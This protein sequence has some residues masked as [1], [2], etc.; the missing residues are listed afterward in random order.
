MYLHI[1]VIFC[2]VFSLFVLHYPLFVQINSR[3][4]TLPLHQLLISYFPAVA[5]LESFPN[6]AK[7]LGLVLHRVQVKI[8]TVFSLSLSL[9]VYFF[10]KELWLSITIISLEPGYRV[11]D[12]HGNKMKMDFRSPHLIKLPG[13]HLESKVVIL[14]RR[15]IPWG[16]LCC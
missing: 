2:V 13:A 10:L 12:N 3:Q 6:S 11:A 1:I 4:V 7:A 9:Q 5:K 8:L 14:V 16:F 15:W